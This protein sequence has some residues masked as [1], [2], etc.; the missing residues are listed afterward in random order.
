MHVEDL[1]KLSRIDENV[2]QFLDVK[3]DLLGISLASGE[4]I[5]CL[6]FCLCCIVSPTSYVSLLESGDGLLE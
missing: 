5:D 3:V 4:H 6:F 2:N 1:A